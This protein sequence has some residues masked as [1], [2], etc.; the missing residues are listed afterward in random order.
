MK[1]EDVSARAINEMINWV[2]ATGAG[3]AKYSGKAFDW[4]STQIPDVIR[5]FLM[6]RAV[7]AGLYMLFATIGIVASTLFIRWVWKISVKM[8]E[9]EGRFEARL[10]GTI[11]GLGIALWGCIEFVGNTLVLAQ[12]WIAPKVFL[13]QELAKLVKAQ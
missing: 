11:G 7:E 9:Y 3:V 13:I 2:Q 4:A 5:Q 10:F 8:G 12:I 1:L 6:W